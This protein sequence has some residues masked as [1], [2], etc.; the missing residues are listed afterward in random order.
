MTGT[1]IRDAIHRGEVEKVLRHVLDTEAELHGLRTQ[2]T[3]AALQIETLEKRLKD[4]QSACET[5]TND[6]QAALEKLESL[7]AK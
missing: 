4:A 6:W 5:L 3:H 1:Q 7:E 2:N